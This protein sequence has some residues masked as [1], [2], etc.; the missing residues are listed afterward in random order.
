MR[1]VTSAASVLVAAATVASAYAQA[2]VAPAAAVPQTTTAAAAPAAAP[3]SS[4]VGNLLVAPT[5]IILEGSRRTAQVTLINTGTATATYRIS[6]IELEMKPDGTVEEVPEATPKDSTRYLL[7]QPNATAPPTLAEAT[8]KASASSLIRYSPRQ[9]TLDPRV[10][11][12]IRLQVRKPAELA[13]GEYR[14]HLLFRAIPNLDDAI[15]LKDPKQGGLSVRLVPIYGVSIPVI[16]RHG[17]TSVSAELKNLSI[18]PLTPNGDPALELTIERHGNRSLYGNIDVRLVSG[19][20]EQ[21]IGSL[22]GVAVYVPLDARK[23]TIP[24]A[25]EKGVL[26]LGARLHVTL[27]DAEKNDAG[28]EVIAEALLNLP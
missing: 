10:A 5:R 26:P 17:E 3:G 20:R 16:V 24:L 18:R 14:S 22:N 1:F 27:R 2:P 7:A 28:G 25:P 19:G 13:A 12:T 21:S 4:A 23:V 6:F 15:L 11:Q 9:V 8:A